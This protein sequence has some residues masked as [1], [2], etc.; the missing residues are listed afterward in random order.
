SPNKVALLF[1]YFD[2]VNVNDGTQLPGGRVFTCLSHDIVA[3]ETTHALLDGMHRRLLLPSNR[4]VLAFHERF[5]DCVAMLQHFTFPELVADQI[6]ATRGAIDLEK[7][8]LTQLA[9]QFGFAT[10]QRTALRDATGSLQEGKWLKDKPNPA[11]YQTVLEPHAR[12]RILVAAVFD[13]F[14]S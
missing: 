12:G 2:S 3:H 5:A 1:G 11:N 10:G 8:I 7:N 14:L 6:R 4:D 9:L 13:A